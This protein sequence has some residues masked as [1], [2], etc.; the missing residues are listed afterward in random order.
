MLSTKNNKKLIILFPIHPTSYMTMITLAMEIKQSNKYEPYIILTGTIKK[1]LPECEKLNI[2]TIC[3][4]TWQ[5]FSQ[6]K[7]NIN[8]LYK[9]ENNNMHKVYSIIIK[10][11]KH[12]H[13]IIDRIEYRYSNKILNYSIWHL[14][15]AGLEIIDLIVL[16]RRIK[17]FI[18]KKDIKACYIYNDSLGGLFALFNKICQEKGIKII[19]PSCAYQDP[20]TSAY[21]RENLEYLQ[22]KNKGGLLLNKIFMKYLPDQYFSYNNKKLLFYSPFEI[23]AWYLL[24]IL[25]KKPWIV[26]ANY[27]DITCVEN[28]Y[29][30]NIRIE[31]GINEKKIKVIPH[32]DTDVIWKSINNSK[33]K[34]RMNKISKY[35]KKKTI[36]YSVPQLYQEGY[37]IGWN[38]YEQHLKSIVS[39]LTDTKQFIQLVLH[40]KMDIKDYA[41]L[42]ESSNCRIMNVPTAKALASADIYISAGSST[43]FWA[44]M[45]GSIV[46]DTNKL[47]ENSPKYYDYL[48]SVFEVND[49][50]CFKYTLNKLISDSIFYNSIKRKVMID[51]S[52]WFPQLDGNTAANI[53]GLI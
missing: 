26:G 14:I 1:Y 25:P 47:Y 48:E 38:K 46:I 16:S 18:F 50:N 5:S 24:S 7:F 12:L 8:K 2:T 35:N 21:R 33:S 10:M 44:I 41:F 42:V 13:R 19:S 4:N 3:S 32:I 49:I 9:Y 6:N 17:K 20:N 31:Y 30:K 51:N 52:K 22:Y 45:S 40:P 29:I 27:S 11:R 15:K 39:I 34:Y 43:N 36:L 28:Y 37:I 53:I 23:I